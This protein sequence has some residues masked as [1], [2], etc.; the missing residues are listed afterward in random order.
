MLDKS[1]LFVI[2]T[3][4]LSSCWVPDC[5]D[6]VNLP[7]IQSAVFMKLDSDGLNKSSL[8]K[9][10]EVSISNIQEIGMDDEGPLSNDWTCSC[11]AEYDYKKKWGKVSYSVRQ[12]DQNFSTRVHKVTSYPLT[13]KK[14]EE[15]KTWAK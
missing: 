6:D 1:I 15:I 11:S 2:L 9:S 7:K 3:L 12:K 4:M 14:Y 8:G 10:N 13:R 5:E